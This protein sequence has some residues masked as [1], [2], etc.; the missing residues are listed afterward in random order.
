MELSVSTYYYQAMKKPDDTPIIFQIESILELIGPTGY[1]A[2]T[3]ILRRTM[4]I[5]KKTVYRIM[6]ENGFLYEKRKKAYS[7]T[8]DSSHNLPKY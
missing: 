6:T 2:M 1:I 4:T 5:N 8:T 7:K 3:A